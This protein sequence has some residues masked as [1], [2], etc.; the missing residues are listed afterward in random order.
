MRLLFGAVMTVSGKAGFVSFTNNGTWEENPTKGSF[1]NRI[2]LTP[3]SPRS[4]S[5][6][7]RHRRQVR[8]EK[9]TFFQPGRFAGSGIAGL[10]G[11]R[12]FCEDGRFFFTH[13][14][15]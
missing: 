7:T 4:S 14:M 5:R 8:L 13:W 9:I 12:G 2:G 11:G 10:S 3:A 1:S 15:A 6:R